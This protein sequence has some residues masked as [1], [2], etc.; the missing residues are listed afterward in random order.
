M[1]LQILQPSQYQLGFLWQT[2]KITVAQEHYAT[3]LTQTIMAGLYP[4]IFAGG[5]KRRKGTVLSACAP[6]ELHEI[7]LQ[8]VTDLLEMEGWDTYYLGANLPVHQVCGEL[9]RR[10]AQ[11]LCLSA[12]I[13]P[14]VPYLGQVISQ[15]RQDAN[16]AQVK[17]LVGGRPFK[18]VEDLWQQLGAD[19]SAGDAQGAVRQAA[20]WQRSGQ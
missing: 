20:A 1:Y 9:E 12:T 10:G 16:L 5:K 8:M 13:L 4:R 14:H 2:G 19:G 15:V 3:A 7:G 18:L 17:V 11:L 6:G